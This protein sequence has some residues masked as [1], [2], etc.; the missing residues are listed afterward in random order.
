MLA[1][2]AVGAP[3]VAVE[4]VAPPLV[5]DIVAGMAV[6]IAGPTAAAIGADTADIVVATDMVMAVDGA[7]AVTASDLALDL[8]IRTMA[9]MAMDIRTP[10]ME[11]PTILIPITRILTIRTRIIPI[12]MLTG[13]LRNNSNMALRSM[14]LPSTGN[15]RTDSRNTDRRN[16]SPTVLRLTHLLPTLG[17]NNSS[18]T[19]K[20]YPRHPRSRPR[21][22]RIQL[23]AMAR[24]LL[25]SP[26]VTTLRMASGIAS[27]KPVRSKALRFG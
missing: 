5:V 26:A 19:P 7:T 2:E 17:R 16:S 25:R 11:P 12:R 1:V 22:S 9:P 20:G 13:R 14:A 10:I 27:G 15:H 23:L 18:N 4:F 6:A 8:G 24:R 3:W 21:R